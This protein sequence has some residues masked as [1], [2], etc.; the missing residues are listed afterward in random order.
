M[1]TTDDNNNQIFLISGID[2]KWVTPKAKIID[3][4]PVTANFGKEATFA[5]KVHGYPKPTVWWEDESGTELTTPTDVCFS[6]FTMINLSTWMTQLCLVLLLKQY[7]KTT[8]KVVQGG[9][10]ANDTLC[11]VRLQGVHL[12]YYAKSAQKKCLK[13]DNV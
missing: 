2:T 13:Y 4:G 8:K 11:N 12:K 5:C 10:Q 7:L 9:N 6:Y 1:T 3:E